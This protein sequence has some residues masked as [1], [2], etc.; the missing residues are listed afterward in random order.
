MTVKAHVF[1]LVFNNLQGHF[2]SV[3][4]V[5]L[6][7]LDGVACVSGERQLQVLRG[8]WMLPLQDLCLVIVLM[9]CGP[10]QRRL[11]LQALPVAAWQK[12]IGLLTQ[13]QP[14]TS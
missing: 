1:L 7:L 12:H 5:N 3:E 14:L 9:F 10:L 11:L 6:W 13:Y 8:R 2:V 4:F